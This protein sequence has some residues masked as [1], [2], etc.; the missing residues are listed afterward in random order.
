[1]SGTRRAL[2]PVGLEAGDCRI[3]RLDQG[4]A[5]R[6]E[7]RGHD[8]QKRRSSGGSMAASA[9]SSS[10][11]ADEA[12]SAEMLRWDEVSAEEQVGLLAVRLFD[13]VRHGRHEE[14]V[15][16]CSSG[17]AGAP[18]TSDATLRYPATAAG[19]E[20]VRRLRRM[21][22]ASDS[23]PIDPVVRAGLL[24][25]F[26]EL[27]APAP[28]GCTD[29]AAGAMLQALQFEA[30]WCITNVA[31]GNSAQCRALVENGALPPLLALLSSGH[32]AARQQAVWAIANIAADCAQVN[33]A[34]QPWPSSRPLRRVSVLSL[35]HPRLFCSCATPYCTAAPSLGCS[36]SRR[37]CSRRAARATSRAARP[38]SSRCATSR[39]PCPT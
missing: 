15:R 29:A 21:L 28:A 1:M 31:S 14:C 23:P 5:L 8:L 10:G 39:G 27:L 19:L 37:H 36:T 30:T 6:K 20:A 34:A 18:S 3:R 35:S 32:N 38:P 25:V 9:S 4:I 17:A 7:R 22:A 11:D 13:Y 26:V 12:W 24:P 33:T 16:L 2:K